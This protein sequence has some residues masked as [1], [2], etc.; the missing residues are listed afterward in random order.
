M[1]VWIVVQ[2]E[3]NRVILSALLPTEIR[4][5]TSLVAVGTRSTISSVARTLLVKH[6]EALALVVD[7]YS[8]DASVISERHATLSQLLAAVAGDIPFKVILCAPEIEAIFFQS[9]D[10]LGRIFPGV[11]LNSHAMWYKAR[12]KEVLR[13]LFEH[14]G[15]PKD[16]TALLA[17]L[18]E[19]DVQQLRSTGP[20]GELIMFIQEV[21]ARSESKV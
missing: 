18:T 21:R 3:S 13:F 6:R 2:G 16:M 7:A 4:A 8:L 20:V 10:M 5:V 11:D 1:K 14:G 17:S 15:G 9:P 12:P 19:E